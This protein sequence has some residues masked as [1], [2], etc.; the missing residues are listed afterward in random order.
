[1]NQTILF[2]S[3]LIGTVALI[4]GVVLG[5]YTRQALVKKRRGTI[6]AKLEKKVV[7]AK[8]QAQEILLQAKEKATSVIAE[9]QEELDQRRKSA[10]RSE[11]L[12]FKREKGLE[13]KI[14]FFEEKEKD[15][16]EKLKRLKKAKENLEITRIDLQG[17]IE[18]VAEFSKK[19]AK[20]EL[21][22]EVEKDC[23][24][25]L[26]G[27]MKKLQ[28]EGEKK[29][30][31]EAQKILGLAIQK[32]ALS[33][34][35]EI[36]TTTL[37]LPSD[38]IKGRI[39]GKEGRNIRA[40]EKAT[41]VELVVDE[42]P[43]TVIISGFNPLRRQIA[44]IAL[45]R[46][47]EDGRIQPARIEEE[48]K[49]AKE[50][51][52][53]QI[54]EFGNNAV[55]ETEIVDFPPK[56]ISLLGKLYFRTS[57]GQNVLAHSLEVA[58]LAAAMAEEIGADAE[59]TKKAGLLHDIGKVVDREV[60]GTHVNIGIKILERFGIKEEVVKAMRS[61][62][63]EYEAETLEAI[64]VK[65]ADQISGARPGARKDTVENYLKRLEELEKIASSVKGVKESYAI[66]AGREL[67]V[68]IKPEEIDDLGAYKLAKDI[69]G[70][71]QQEL[72]YPGE[73]KVNV[74]RETRVEEYAR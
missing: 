69:A 9:A 71:I 64:L 20:E 37:S 19:E 70:R 60:E 63:G 17:K 1:M 34:A 22:K 65:I 21:L 66:H 2:L 58:F 56:L 45:Q 55:Y 53:N 52:E 32:Y 7:E 5:Y 62:H 40:F 10:L 3:L 18:K 35:Q 30:K 68:F 29:L 43:G 57:Y 16:D 74:I 15:F 12:L 72:N 48:T 25:E 61:H 67:R 24:T 26:M 54:E 42:T 44:K 14:S 46:L 49:K 33:Q 23:Q 51:I 59:L 41:G 28:E 73:I 4:A 11:E 8:Q 39:I 31:I 47:I 6:E 27:R 36:T 38:E 50:E 13:D